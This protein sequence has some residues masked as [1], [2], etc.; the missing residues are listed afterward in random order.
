MDEYAEYLYMR[1]PHYRK[2]DP[3][4]LTVQKA[5]RQR[6]KCKPFKWFIENIAFD[7][8]LSY[9]FIEPPDFG[10]GE[11]R[12]Y[13][14][15]IKNIRKR[16]IDP[17]FDFCVIS[18]KIR[19]V[20]ASSLCIDSEKKEPEETFGLKPCVKNTNIKNPRSEQYFVLTWHEDIRPKKRNVCWD[21]SSVSDKATV[22][23]YK[24]HGMKGNQLWRYKPVK[25]F[26]LTCNECKSICN[27]FLILESLN[28][29]KVFFFIF[30]FCLQ[31]QKLLVH[32]TN[33][34]CLTANVESQ[35]IYVT[36]CDPNSLAQ[37]WNIEKFNGTAA[38]R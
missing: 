26:L 31:K 33:N 14:D 16:I 4:D 18:L 20:A 28:V 8:P 12:F 5:V 34:R 36:K 2:I 11:V 29:F 3:G 19:S 35:T 25:L 15:Y 27:D 10:E 38:T 6:L 22:N 30:F 1:R 21:V 17:A 7:L 13:R 9:P 32:G 37:K 24:C 23:L